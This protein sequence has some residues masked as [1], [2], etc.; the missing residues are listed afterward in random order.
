MATGLLGHIEPFNWAAE[1]WPQYVE[2]LEQF[3]V[4]ND[5]TGEDNAVKR[6]ATFL[7]VVGRSAYNLLRSLITPEKPTAK[8]YGQ[9]VEV[10]TEHYSPKP[11][12]VMQRFRFNS[13][14]RKEGESVADYVAELRKLAEFCNFG[15]SLN[16]MPRDR[17]VWGIKD[18]HTQK[19]LLA[20]HNLTLA[21]TIQ[22]AQGAETAEKNL[23]EMSAGENLKDKEGV[24]VVKKTASGPSEG[25]CHRCDKTGHSGTDCPYKDY[26]CRSCRRVGHLQKVCRS[27][28]GRANPREF[29]LSAKPRKHRDKIGVSQIQDSQESD[30]EEEANLWLVEE[31]GEVNRVYQPPITV[32]V[33]I[34][35]ISVAMEL[36]TGASVSLI[37]ESQYRQL[38][39]GRRLSTSYIQLQTYSKEPLIVLGTI[40]VT[41]EYESQKVTLPLV[42]VKGGG[43]ILFGRNWLRAIKLNW[44]NIH[45]T[46]STGLQ[47]VLRK[48]LDVFQKGLGTFKGPE[49]S[50]VV[51]PDATPRFNK[52][53]PLP[54]AM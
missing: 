41:V 49:V 17:L 34:D 23:R 50:L 1:E 54:Y 29:Q 53:R 13:R 32:L 43:P 14:S 15:A 16:K 26:V 31:V 38:W 37:S 4:A 8:T 7:T 40:E 48:Y 35:G 47:D 39:G 45:Y 11:T 20:E 27:A 22:I 52:A 21:S 28:G 12:E 51:D 9:L 10:L 30:S 5:I 46:Q 36:D 44:S 42:V 24:K 18:P 2:R 25:Q 33:R 19:K 6:R 3:F